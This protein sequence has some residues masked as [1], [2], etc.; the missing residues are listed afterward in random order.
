MKKDTHPDDCHSRLESA[1]T[2]E[3]IIS[4]SAPLTLSLL[5]NTEEGEQIRKQKYSLLTQWEE[6]RC[7]C[8]TDRSSMKF[9][10]VLESACRKLNGKADISREVNISCVRFLREK[11]KSDQ[12][13]SLSLR[14]HLALLPQKPSGESS[15]NTA[16]FS[17]SKHQ[18]AL[19]D[20]IE[21]LGSQF[22]Q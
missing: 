9:R 4:L 19:S 16:L 17:L 2:E 22:E 12:S 1:R 21:T 6:T 7:T 5:S 11:L 20:R 13:L 3:S 18:S 14:Q 8:H 10:S 15:L